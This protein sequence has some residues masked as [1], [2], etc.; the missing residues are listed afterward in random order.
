M[1]TYK[2]VNIEWSINH[3][4]MQPCKRRIQEKK[5]PELIGGL[6]MT[7]TMS[8]STSSA[9]SRR[10]TST[11]KPA[12]MQSA[13]CDTTV[14][15]LMPFMAATSACINNHS[16]SWLITKM[17]SH[18]PASGFALPIKQLPQH[19]T[20]FCSNRATSTRQSPWYQRLKHIYM[21]IK[22]ELSG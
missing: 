18:S 16:W 11:G 19:A 4:K 13:R 5:L 6:R 15:G 20:F 22:A 12:R 8:F 21:G 10:S 14:D 2:N 1:F 3:W 17:S 7:S 9:T